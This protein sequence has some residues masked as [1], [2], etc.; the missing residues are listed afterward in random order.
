M[1]KSALTID[2]DL[3]TANISRDLKEEI[4]LIRRLKPYI[5]QCLT[6]NHDINNPLS[7]ILGYAEFILSEGD[8]LTEDQRSGLEHILKCGERIK[9]I[10]ESL[11]DHKLALAE[12]ID[13]ESITS[14]YKAYANRV[15]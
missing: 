8:A 7:G 3:K 14:A 1:A 2:D 4:T 13:L 11:G 6:M 12:K 5:G 9:H 15:D 10:V